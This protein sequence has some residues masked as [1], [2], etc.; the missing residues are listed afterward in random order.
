MV[1]IQIL[2]YN[3]EQVAE[4]IPCHVSLNSAQVLSTTISRLKKIYELGQKDNIF[5]IY[6]K[7]HIIFSYSI[8]PDVNYMAAS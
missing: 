7:L 1:L 4:L 6:F 8:L 3:V 5:F 2:S